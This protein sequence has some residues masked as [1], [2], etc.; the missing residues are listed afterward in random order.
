[1]T[2]LRLFALAALWFNST[3]S[4]QVLV[5]LSSV[6]LPGPVTQARASVDGTRLVVQL[7][8]RAGA[9]APLLVFD[10]S[11]PKDPKQLGLL[12]LPANG[13]MALSGDGRR[14]LVHVGQA[15]RT[16]NAETMRT[17]VAVDLAEPRSPRILW[18]QQVA[19]I[20]VALPSQANAYA[21]TRNV[22]GD[23]GK[24]EIVVVSALDRQTR[25]TIPTN[26]PG[27]RHIGF[28]ARGDFL[29]QGRYGSLEIWDLKSKPPSKVELEASYGGR[30]NGDCRPII[31]DN[32]HVAM[33]DGR[34]SRLGIYK[35][36]V[37]MPRVATLVV[38][39]GF[40]CNVLSPNAEN[41]PY[42]FGDFYGHVSR[43]DLR[44]ARAPVARGAWQLPP[45][46]FPLATAG[47][48]LFATATDV[49]LQIFRP[50]AGVSGSSV[51]GR[52]LEDAHRSALESLRAG[53]QAGG[54]KSSARWKAVKKLEDA[55]ILQALTAPISGVSNRQ[56]AA[57]LND[58]GFLASQTYRPNSVAES[59]LRKA[60]ALHPGRAVAHLNL[61]DLLRRSLGK[62][63]AAGGDAAR[64]RKEVEN[65]Y[66]TY[67]ANGGLASPAITAYLR[68]DPG[69]GAKNDCEA[70]AAWANAGRLHELMSD[71]GIN[72]PWQG[73]RI[74]LIFT[75]EGT[76]HV[77]AFYAFD[78]KDDRPIAPDVVSSLEG[79]V[80][81]LWGGDQL[82]ILTVGRRYHVLHYR[83]AKHPVA[84]VPL[85][86][87]ETCRF[88]V[89]TQEEIGP[90]AVEPELCAAIKVGAPPDVL[91][92]D[93]EV[94][95]DRA[96]I[97]EAW[98]ETGAGGARELD[99]SND[100]N[101]M[102]V[103]E[104]GLSSGAGPGCESKFFDLLDPD[105]TQ[106]LKGTAR[107]KLMEL[108]GID[109]ESGRATRCGNHARFFSH[110]GRV[111]FETW[112]ADWPPR[113]AWHQYH[114]VATVRN[115]QVIDV[116]DFKFESSVS[117]R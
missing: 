85:G 69:A 51:D 59:A 117:T 1:M 11:N 47:D 15:A 73:K 12:N 54:N 49:K 109:G 36:R 83:D 78:A 76:A 114:R 8:A 30:F 18:V 61:A 95:L 86:D 107:N 88:E 104:L 101:P 113:D 43:I 79:F 32:G 20:D 102:N 39:D 93:T 7:Q 58:Y 28:S 24:H 19:A 74:D 5:P 6:P 57:I 103:V 63:A 87:G 17:I 81:G 62:I 4:A 33:L 48:L 105:G 116:C 46:T 42:E 52:V 60:I 10:T 75:T 22:G 26:D 77:P 64:R 55:G 56:A 110:D 111:Y 108:Q 82:G 115:D 72:L 98:R 89:V 70:I 71:V 68:G 44:S 37:G 3:A 14:V 65:H 13:D 97:A 2:A 90:K 27:F 100:G 92:F 9:P 34:T 80:E 40:H 99:F 45:T 29:A 21:F 112:P 91:A 38:E 41:V 66:R 106:I 31:L 96:T 23:A 35:A 16:R 50:G 25:T 94:D 53:E 84:T 67:L